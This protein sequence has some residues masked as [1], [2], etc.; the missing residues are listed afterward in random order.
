[1]AEIGG[2]I[3]INGEVPPAKKTFN[4]PVLTVELLYGAAVI[5]HSR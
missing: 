2:N 5:Y 4:K 1:M 3:T